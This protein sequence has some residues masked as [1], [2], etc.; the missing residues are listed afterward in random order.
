VRC[1]F[2]VA[3][4]LAGCG[5]SVPG[6]APGDARDDA[7]A[8]ATDAPID[9]AVPLGPWGTPKIITE[10]SAGGSEDD[11]TLTGDL[12]EVYFNLNGDIYGSA[13]GT[14]SAPWP[15]PVPIAAVNSTTATET[16]P[17]VSP[18][19]LELFFSSNRLGGTGGHDIY[20]SSRQN[21][22]DAF[23][24]PVRIAELASGNDDVTATTFTPGALVM[25]F[26]SVRAGSL[27][28]YRTTRGS[29]TGMWSTPMLVAELQTPG[30]ET[31]PTLTPSDTYMILSSD[32]P[33]IRDLFVTTR[34]TVSDPWDTPVPITELNTGFSEEDP[35]LSPDGRTLVFASTRDGAYELYIVTR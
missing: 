33:G 5:F 2:A 12:L 22:G 9:M 14:A 17:E 10:L 18:D 8:D 25:Y 19:G 34:A 11:P 26:T 24:T 29:R 27:D 35:W 32:G 15:M 28:M 4:A 6:S 20:V 13:R 30:V 7:P 21:R 1:L 23:G 16:T 31:E 3:A